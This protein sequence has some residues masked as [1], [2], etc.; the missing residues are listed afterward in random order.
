MICANRD[1]ASGLRE[2]TAL[3]SNTGVRVFAVVGGRSGV[4]K[5][6]SVINLATALAKMGKR[7]LIL[8]ENPRHKDVNANLGLCARYDLLH[9]INR[10]KTLEQVMTQGPEGVMVLTAM[11]GIHS[12]AKLAPADQER[13][14][15]CFS[16]LSQTVDAVL[17]DTAIGRGSRVVPLSLASQQVLIVLS[18]SGQAIT[19]AYALIKLISKEYARRDFLVLVNKVQSE[20]RGREI[21]ENIAS[22][23][24]KNLTV[25]LEWMGCI[26]FDDKLHRSTRLCQPVVEIF[27]ASD[28]A[29][30]YRQLAE[31][32]MRCAGHWTDNDGVENFMRR[33]IRTSHLDAAE[34]TV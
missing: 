10:D 13:L 30:G 14:I 32:L 1:Q 31:K 11:R 28:S 6:C 3:E 8:D 5:T 24:Q 26:L 34:F 23:A 25:R 17:I 29:A 21:F 22:V 33:L 7:V 27:P 20:S 18:G 9:V 16:E 12:L 19:D 15:E 2:L 4:G